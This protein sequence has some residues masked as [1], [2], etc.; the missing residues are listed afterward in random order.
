MAGHAIVAQPATL[1]GSIGIY[2]GKMA[3]G[4]AADKIGLT[5]EAVTMGANADIYSPFDPFTPEQRDKVQA[6][7]EDFYQGFVSKAAASRGKMPEEIDAVARGRVWTGAQALTHGL[8]DRL[9]GLDAAVA[10]AKERAGIPADE[11]VQ[12]VV[13]PARRT[14]YEALSEQ[15]GGGAAGPLGGL[16]PALAPFEA[17]ATAQEVAAAGRRASAAASGRLF[18]RGE[19]L[20]LMPLVIVR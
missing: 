11:E 17:L 14:L 8:V 12:L 4:G 1:T 2:S 5:A 20:A 7:M 3:L 16:A 19:P 15:F 13:Y 9:G 18:R 6:F 10:L